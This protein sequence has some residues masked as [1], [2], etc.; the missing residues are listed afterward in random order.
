LD[1]AVA[2]SGIADAVIGPVGADGKRTGGLASRA[3]GARREVALAVGGASAALGT[4]GVADYA[5]DGEVNLRFD[6]VEK[7]PKHLID[8]KTRPRPY[9]PIFN[10]GLDSEVRLVM[11]A[12]PNLAGE[13]IVISGYRYV[14][15]KDGKLV[16]TE[17][18]AGARASD[19]L[20]D[21]KQI[22]AQRRN[23]QQGGGG[24]GGGNAPK[25]KVGT[26]EQ[27]EGWAQA[28]GL[29]TGK[30]ALART[31]D[32]GDDAFGY[33]L[34]ASNSDPAIQTEAEK[35]TQEL[36]RGAAGIFAASS[37][38]SWAVMAARRV[39]P[40]RAP[41]IIARIPAARPTPKRAPSALSMP[42]CSWSFAFA[43]CAFTSS[44]RPLSS[45]STSGAAA[46]AGAGGATGAAA[47][48]R[49]S[50]TV[51]RTG[52]PSFAGTGVP[53][54]ATAETKLRTAPCALNRMVGRC[55]GG[56]S[57][58]ILCSG[59]SASAPRLE[60]VVRSMAGGLL[61]AKGIR[62]RWCRRASARRCR[63]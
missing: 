14:K 45:S 53:P 30:S 44:S 28:I 32:D 15:D 4:L 60:I 33:R 55:A 27:R 25:P 8:S 17:I 39:V 46:A 23:Q 26:P 2:P 22:A 6:R 19:V 7:I 24:G 41:A 58:S 11:L 51:R 50:K 52:S 5:A 61:G 31:D 56:A 38:A 16:A 9:A 29:A 62:R 3:W 13:R 18:P 1:V 42:F 21:T 37:P 36:M 47:L 59:A 48:V 35:L 63:R 40:A 20:A 49:I 10:P 57:D 12:A 54:S 34:N 43:V